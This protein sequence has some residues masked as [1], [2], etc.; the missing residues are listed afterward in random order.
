LLPE[1]IA[2]VSSAKHKQ[3]Y[4]LVHFGYH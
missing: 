4:K 1:Y 3:R 2:A